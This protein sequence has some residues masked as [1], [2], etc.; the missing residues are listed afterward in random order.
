MKVNQYS[1]NTSSGEMGTIPCRQSVYN[2]MW[3]LYTVKNAWVN[4]LANYTG[5]TGMY[6]DCD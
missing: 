6:E 2:I 4:T 5:C 3:L 1:N